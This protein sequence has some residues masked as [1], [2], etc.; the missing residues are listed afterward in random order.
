[1]QCIYIGKT[2]YI[3]AT[4]LGNLFEN[5]ILFIIFDSSIAIDYVQ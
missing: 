1:M 3:N 2:D 4:I 5:I